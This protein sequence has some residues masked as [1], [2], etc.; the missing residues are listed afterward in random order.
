MTSGREVQRLTSGERQE[1]GMEAG[2]EENGGVTAHEERG[3]EDERENGETVIEG[4]N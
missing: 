2:G 3:E 1:A 4:G